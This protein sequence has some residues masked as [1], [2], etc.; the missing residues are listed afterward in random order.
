MWTTCV[1]KTP[2]GCRMRIDP[3]LLPLCLCIW[4]GAC[5]SACV[6]ER[7]LRTRVALVLSLVYAWMT[8][9]RPKGSAREW[10]SGV[11]FCRCWVEHPQ[12]SG[13]GTGVC[14]HA[15]FSP[16]PPLPP[17]IHH[18]L[19][20]YWATQDGARGGAAG[21]AAGE[22]GLKVAPALALSLSLFLLHVYPAGFCS[23]RCAEIRA[24]NPECAAAILDI[25][26]WLTQCGKW[27]GLCRLLL[28]SG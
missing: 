12:G 25:R 19:T 26:S 4:G 17:R 7:V 13:R 6:C 23:K 14:V 27:N 28:R 11:T 18:L 21:G 15:C 1:H 2:N 22:E 8:M 16:H 5:L 24:D 3:F 10:E 20:H 9:F